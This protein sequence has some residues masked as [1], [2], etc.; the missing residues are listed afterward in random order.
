[1]NFS[2]FKVIVRA[3]ELRKLCIDMRVYDMSVSATT[4]T[5]DFG[6]RLASLRKQKGWSQRDLAG[7]C[8]LSHRMIAYYEA[9]GGEPPAHVIVQLCKALQVSADE[10]LGLAPTP[11]VNPQDVRLWRRLLKV[12]DFA[13]KDRKVVTDMIDALEAKTD[14]QPVDA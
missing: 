7:K 13:D 2:E 1:L 5:A 8:G 6:F 9:Q 12:Q 3:T 14:I 11:R 10:L 4:E